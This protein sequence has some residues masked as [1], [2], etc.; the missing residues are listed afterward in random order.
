MM[1]M[2]ACEILSRRFACDRCRGQKLRCL[3][4]CPDQQ[5]CDRCFRADAECR[6]SSVFCARSY[7][8]DIAW[9]STNSM[10]EKARV[11]KSVRKRRY[12]G[13]PRL[14]GQLQVGPQ[15]AVLSTAI[16]TETE[17]A[18]PSRSFGQTTLMNAFGTSLSSITMPVYPTDFSDTI[19]NMYWEAEDSLFSGLLLPAETDENFGLS[20]N[21]G[22][23]SST[24]S[25]PSQAPTYTGDLPSQPRPSLIPLSQTESSA[26]T[27]CLQN[28]DCSSSD[29]LS[30]IFENNHLYES[31]VDQVAGSISIDKIEE[32]AIV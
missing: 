10:G 22:T 23:G 13:A 1:D 30:T 28:I 24:E 8:G 5:C 17:S 15:Q 21:S 31:P 2:N 14:Q 18:S 26:P 3:R 12:N 29:T 4:E 32:K 20:G 11:Q 7:M 6:T 25:Y 9:S 19:S 27:S 16:V